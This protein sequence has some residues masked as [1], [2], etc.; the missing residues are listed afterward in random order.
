MLGRLAPVLGAWTAQNVSSST[1]VLVKGDLRRL[2]E[3]RRRG[4]NEGMLD[5]DRVWSRREVVAAMVMDH[6]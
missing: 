3:S 1:M 5:G 2:V 6:N 4:A